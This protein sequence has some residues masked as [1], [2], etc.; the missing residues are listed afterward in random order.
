MYDDN[1]LPEKGAG[2]FDDIVDAGSYP[3]AYLYPIKK[4]TPVKLQLGGI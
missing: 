4:Q 1:G 3:I 2:K